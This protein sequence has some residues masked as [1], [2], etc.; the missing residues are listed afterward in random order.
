MLGRA[1][2]IVLAQ[3]RPRRSV[4][5]YGSAAVASLGGLTTLTA[6]CDGLQLSSE[7]PNMSMIIP[8][9][10][11]GLRAAR[12][13]KTAMLIIIDYEIAKLKPMIRGDEEIGHQR[14]EHEMELR[15]SELEN[16]Q[17][18]YANEDEDQSTKSLPP[19]ERRALKLKQKKQMEEAARLL[20]D[21]EEALEAMEGGSAKSKVHRTSANR[22]LELCKKNG[23]VYIKVGQHLANLDYLIPQEY[24]DALSTLFDS[25]PRSDY[26]NVRRV[27]REDLNAEVDSL[28]E[29][30][31]PVPLASA[32]LGQVHVAYD[33]TSGR[34]LAVKVQHYGL[35][36]TSAGDIFA[37]ST[38]VR[39]IESMFEGF[40]FGWIADEIAPHLPKELDFVREGKNA[41]LAA[42]HINKTGLDCVI[43]KII[44]N[45]TSSRVLTMEF[46]EG[47]KATDVDAIEASGLNK[48]YVQSCLLAR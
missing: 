38:V 4:V 3:R 20:A 35:R 17:M 27:I 40:T 34:K 33:K 36:E 29:N 24:I 23:G 8:T 37:V 1:G 25:C 32:S 12:L 13:V 21:A 43:P 18:A 15:E 45:K 11:A 28:F 9:M 47:F 41:E 16:A 19:L 6:G 48:R 2:A 46:E 26:E 7:R 30:F 31:D 42:M 14:L 10:Q 22:L 5:L 39:L 44:W